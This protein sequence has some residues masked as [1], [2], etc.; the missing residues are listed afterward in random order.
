MK[1]IISLF[2]FL[3]V[4]SAH[5]VSS[6]L[7]DQKTLD[8][9]QS[10]SE[11]EK[12]IIY[13]EKHTTQFVLQTNNQGDYLRTD[14]VFVIFHG[15]YNSPFFAKDMQNFLVDKF[16]QNTV[17]V[18]LSHH[19][20]KNRKNLDKV[21][22]EDWVYQL[23]DLR[24]LLHQL[25]N[26]LVLVGHSTGGLLA[27]YT[28]FKDSKN[29]EALLLFAPAIELTRRSINR[30]KAGVHLGTGISDL[31]GRYASPYAA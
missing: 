2:I 30:A 7:I 9:I 6:E 28:T 4:F 19:F 18:R 13:A 3:F 15:L 11:V 10:F 16:A 5:A 8:Q 23:E 31:K 22:L 14:R 24:P 21:K 12:S 27:L 25:G 17:T 20:E 29:I 1:K 26:K